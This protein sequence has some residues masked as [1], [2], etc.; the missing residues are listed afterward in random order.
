MKLLILILFIF[1]VSGCGE[2]AVDKLSNRSKNELL[3][4]DKTSYFI[5]QAYTQKTITPVEAYATYVWHRGGILK[6]WY[7]D[8]N[9]M[10]DS[11]KRARIEDAKKYIIWHKQLKDTL[12]Q[13]P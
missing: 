8:Y 9:T 10:T 7:D 2:G 3:L 6:S 4:D 5:E 12:I 13:I 1:M 11:S